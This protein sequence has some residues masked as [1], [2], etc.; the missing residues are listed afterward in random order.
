MGSGLAW[1]VV[2]TSE[3]SGRAFNYQIFFAK[4]IYWVVS[5]PVAILALGLLSG[6]SWATILF[7]IFLS[8]IW[9][10]EPTLQIKS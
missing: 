10:V 9:Y 6:V 3:N 4:Y 8:W 5:F 7:N 2:G 1:S